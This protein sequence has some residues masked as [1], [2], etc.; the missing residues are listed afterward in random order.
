MLTIV[1]PA[2][3]VVLGAL[4]YG[5]SNNSKVGQLALYTFASGMLVLVYGLASKMIHF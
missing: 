3:A 2:L 1:T 4:T 5:L